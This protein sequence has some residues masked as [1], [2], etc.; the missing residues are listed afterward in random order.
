[1]K[2]L[3]FDGKLDLKEVQT[4]AP[5]GGEALVRV[6]LAGI[7]MTDIEIVKGYMNF[8]GILGHEFVGHVENSSNPN[9][10]GMRVVGDINVGC[11]KCEL[12]LKGLERHC[13]DRSVLGIV[14]RNG[15]FAEYLTLPDSNLHVVPE[16]VSDEA[17]VFVEPLAAAL[18]VLEQVHVEPS[19]EVLIIGDGRLGLLLCM[20]LR[21]TGCSLTVVGKHP[22]KLSLFENYSAGAMLLDDIRNVSKKYD[23]VIE[24]SGNPSGW[25]TA[26]GLVKPRG[27]IVLKSTYHGDFRFNPAPLVINE[28]SVIG[29]RCGQFEPALRLLSSGLVNPLPLITEVFKMDDAVKAFEKATHSEALKIIIEM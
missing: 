25:I 17:A 27:T 21:L 28:I 16:N 11:G 4:P 10:I 26:I 20:V 22:H 9:L 23:L 18:E 2:A 6:R 14:T 15:A 8:R 3:V 7:C 13:Y 24:A 29:S 1:M 5:S 12:C 19:T